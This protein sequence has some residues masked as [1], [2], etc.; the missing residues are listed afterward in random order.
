MPK[1]N[2]TPISLADIA[3]DFIDKLESGDPEALKA[4]E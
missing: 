3:R 4:F 2:K 1:P